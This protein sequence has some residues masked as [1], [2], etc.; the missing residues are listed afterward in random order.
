MTPNSSRIK[1]VL[2]LGL[3]GW[4]LGVMAL[5]WLVLDGPGV[6]SIAKRN[7]DFARFVQTVSAAFGYDFDSPGDGGEDS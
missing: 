3:A 5:A 6:S 1:P 7:A 4:M 2:R